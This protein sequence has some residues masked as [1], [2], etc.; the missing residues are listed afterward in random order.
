MKRAL[1]LCLIGASLVAAGCDKQR[2]MEVRTYELDRITF[3]DAT[4]LVTPYV[5]EGG[6]V[7]GHKTG[8]TLTIRETPERLEQI[9]AVL[10]RHDGPASTVL[11]RFQIIEAN[12]FTG[13]D[14]A[15]ADVEASLRELFRYTGYRLSREVLVRVAEGE[16]FNQ[17][18]GTEFVLRGSVRHVREEGAER[19]IPVRIELHLS[20]G[21]GIESTIN[22]VIGETVVIGTA[23]SS[24]EGALILA[25]R[26]ELPEA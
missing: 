17:G 7:T 20:G 25:V 23:A 4:A 16:H 3:D 5:R 24:G 22:A 6:T 10:E 11:L 9:E 21:R 12:G 8:G 18:E 15:I 14:S 26:A 13:R 2:G 19:A 1:I